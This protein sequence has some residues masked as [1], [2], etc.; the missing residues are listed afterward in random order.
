[1]AYKVYE[2]EVAR[3]VGEY[4]QGGEHGEVYALDGK[5]RRGMRKKDEE[6]QEYGLSVYDVQ[7]GESAVPSGSGTQGK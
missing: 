2:Q 1:M 3:L 4:N 5:A 6:G 7:Q